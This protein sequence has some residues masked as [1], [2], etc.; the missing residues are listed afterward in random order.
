MVVVVDKAIEIGPFAQ[1][2]LDSPFGKL[3]ETCGNLGHRH[4]STS[5]GTGPIRSQISD[6][7]A[8]AGDHKTLAPL[9]TPHDLGIVVAELALTDGR[10]HATSVAL[11]CYALMPSVASTNSRTLPASA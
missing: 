2:I 11:L 1:V 7:R 5:T 3:S 6:R 9:H 8:I 10:A 4:E